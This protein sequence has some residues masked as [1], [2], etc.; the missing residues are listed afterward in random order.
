MFVWYSECRTTQKGKE[1]M[2]TVHTTANGTE[3]QA[4]SSDTPHVPRSDKVIDDN[5]P[6]GS[7]EA[8]MNYC[9]NPDDSENL[10]CYT[11]NPN[12]TREYCNISLCTGVSV[13]SNIVRRL[14]RWIN[15]VLNK[16]AELPQRWPRDMRAVYGCPEKFRESLSTPTATFAEIFNGL[17]FLS[18]LWMCGQN[19]KF[20]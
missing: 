4:W 10:W 17:L 13:L 14:Y 7:V 6:D 9:R 2:G 16:K 12:S 19:L 3:C 20:V 15:C 11:M 5:F 1:Y 18:I 8:A